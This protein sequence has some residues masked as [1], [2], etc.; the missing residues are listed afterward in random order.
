M[1]AVHE[2][3][4]LLTVCLKQRVGEQAHLRMHGSLDLEPS[5]SLL[6]TFS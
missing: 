4:E 1:G 5:R 2:L 3:L 6:G